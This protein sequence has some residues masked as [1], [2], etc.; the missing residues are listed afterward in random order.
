MPLSLPVLLMMTIATVVCAQPGG[1]AVSGP[2]TLTRGD[3]Q[4]TI[5][6]SGQLNLSIGGKRFLS[7]SYAMMIRPGGKESLWSAGEARQELRLDGSGDRPARVLA[8]S[9]IPGILRQEVSA[10]FADQMLSVQWRVKFGALAEDQAGGYR[11]IGFFIPWATIDGAELQAETHFSADI[12]QAR[13][14]ATLGQGNP[15]PGATRWLRLHDGP[16]SVR[17]EPLGM[18]VQSRPEGYRIVSG[19]R[20]ESE[21]ELVLGVLLDWSGTLD[22][23]D[24]ERATGA[25]R[26]NLKH[27]DRDGYAVDACAGSRLP[28]SAGEPGQVVLR[29][30]ALNPGAGEI[31]ARYRIEDFWDKV[32]AEGELSLPADC[33][34][35]CVLVRDI[36]TDRTGM[37]RFMTDY[38]GADGEKRSAQ[39][40]YAVVPVRGE[41]PEQWDSPFGM[42]LPATA[43]HARLG[44]Q[45]GVAWGRAH[46]TMPYTQWRNAEP[47]E[48]RWAWHDQEYALMIEHGFSILG[49]LSAPPAWAVEKAGGRNLLEWTD[50]DM[51]MWRRYCE[52]VIAHYSDNIRY[53]EVLNEP[54]GWILNERDL[55]VRKRRAEG[56]ARLLRI[57]HETAK[58]IDPELRIVGVCGPPGYYSMEWYPLTFKAGALQYTD[59]LSAHMYPTFFRWPPRNPQDWDRDLEPDEWYRQVR[60]YLKEHGR[61]DL[62]IWN[63]EAGSHHVQTFYTDYAPGY[64]YGARG[65]A[66]KERVQSFRE[67]A[68]YTVRAAIIDLANGVKRFHYTGVGGAW[69]FHSIAEGDQTPMPA[70]VAWAVMTHLL[71]GARYQTR[72]DLGP[73]AQCHVF[74]VPGGAVAVVW[75]TGR[76][77]QDWVAAPVWLPLP[78]DAVATP[79]E[80][81]D[82]AAGQTMPARIGLISARDVMGVD[83]PLRV[84]GRTGFALSEQPV[85]LEAP[86]MSA[87]A[88]SDELRAVELAE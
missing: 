7:D 10:I 64:S 25:R 53:W 33:G 14:D 9:E 15:A 80:L 23:S 32:V 29:T 1:Q 17:V 73:L 67:A 18:Q 16:K 35:A 75:G 13:I 11:E 38:A 39:A 69:Y 51:Q 30:V 24:Y 48:G 84:N 40:L 42:H 83:L 56:Y 34:K 26:P 87:R 21:Q 37:F 82:L 4:L 8:S 62:E 61:E 70:M 2:Q 68:M 58:A 66:P 81:A 52:A 79:D 55:A 12:M 72:V 47:E 19:G 78:G 46:D 54:Y 65:P 28:Y 5:A 63:T 88:L 57:A 3:A 41:K 27:L 59:I 60:G 71:D 49:V 43:H 6:P 20:I 44:E 31:P 77:P 22:G 85:W 50:E 76:S 36:P 45:I 86:G 74:E